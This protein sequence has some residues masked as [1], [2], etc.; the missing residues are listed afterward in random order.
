MS[1]S[2]QSSLSGGGCGFQPRHDNQGR[3]AFR[4]KGSGNWFHS[5]G[6]QVKKFFGVAS[7]E[8]VDVGGGEFGER[9]QQ[10]RRPL[11]QFPSV[12]FLLVTF[13]LFGHTKGRKF[14]FSLT[15]AS[16]RMSLPKLKRNKEMTKHVAW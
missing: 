14:K 11:A 6:Q 5:K 8:T 3:N 10:V 13:H 4:E 12:S 9:H 2:A 1:L 16:L 7:Y 15:S